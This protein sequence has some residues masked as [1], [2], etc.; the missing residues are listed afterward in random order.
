MTDLALITIY[1]F[2]V[3]RQALLAIGKKCEFYEIRSSLFES[4]QEDMKLI[5]VSGL[6]G[7]GKSVA[8]HTLEDEEFH[9]IDNLHLGLLSAFVKRLTSPDFDIYDNTAVGIDARSGATELNSFPSIIDEIRGSGLDVDVLYLD[10]EVPTLLKRFSETR[11]R[12]PL[13]RNGLPL[14]EA[15]HLERSLLS[16]IASYA[17]LKIDTTQT[18]IH[19]LRALIR[20]RVSRKQDSSLSL[21]FQSFGY[22]HGVPPD[23]D[24]VFD[25]RCLP[26]PHWESKLRSLTGQDPEVVDYLRSHREV[27]EMFESLRI[28]LEQWIPVFES[29]NRRYLSVSIGCTGGQHRSVYLAERLSMHFRHALN[30]SVSLRHRELV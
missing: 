15:I 27:E 12:H 19:Q 22:K 2:C 18:T 28:F 26:N 5:I 24:Y 1:E 4:V 21:L 3:Q 13:T 30:A 6:S 29:E 20:E 8:L 11:R 10:A 23:S 7:S 17:D 25:V 16:A 14:V 9:C